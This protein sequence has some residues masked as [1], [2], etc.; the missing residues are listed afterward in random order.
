MNFKIIKSSEITTSG[1]NYDPLSIMHYGPKT[2]SSNGKET[3]SYLNGTTV[4]IGQRK[5]LSEI[6]KIEVER[7]Y[8]CKERGKVQSR[9]LEI[10]Q[11]D[12]KLRS[13]YYFS[14][15]LG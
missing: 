14:L 8:S 10:N 5:G 2:F 3:V 7:F 12:N 1:T 9:T 13:P 15:L 11:I 4:G 6:D